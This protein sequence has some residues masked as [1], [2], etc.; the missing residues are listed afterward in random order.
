[1]DT[2]TLAQFDELVTASADNMVAALEEFNKRQPNPEA[3]VC[4]AKDLHGEFAEYFRKLLSAEIEITVGLQA[5][6][7]GRV[8]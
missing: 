2:L 8:Y 5:G 1:M 7:S 6:E 3:A 4:S